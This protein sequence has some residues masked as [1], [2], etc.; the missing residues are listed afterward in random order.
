MPE[1]ERLEAVK[2]AIELGNDINAVARF[3]DLK[4]TGEPEYTLLYY[5]H[6]LKELQ[7]LGMGDPRWSGSTALHGSIIANQPSITQYLVDHGA[8]IDAKTDTGWTPLMMTR[9]VFLA[10]TGRVFPATEAI[11]TKAAAERSSRSN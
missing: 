2:T 3:G 6:N 1:A 9:G 7:D 11:L 8:N 4:M 10:N 5:P